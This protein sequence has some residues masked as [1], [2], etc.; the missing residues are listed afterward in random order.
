MIGEIG[1]PR[2]THRVLACWM[3]ASRPLSESLNDF[4]IDARTITSANH[5]KKKK[6]SP[7]KH[8][9]ENK[10]PNFS[11]KNPNF[12]SPHQTLASSLPF[13][14]S[15]SPLFVALKKGRAKT[16]LLKWGFSRCHVCIIGVVRVKIQ[17]INLFFLISPL[18]YGTRTHTH[19]PADAKGAGTFLRI[20]PSDCT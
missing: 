14:P 20:S 5:P 2:A 11:T 6:K 15:L 12:L 18:H 8:N 1:E 9:F 17:I 16:R 3:S 7:Q 4:L 10:N 13:P 19:T